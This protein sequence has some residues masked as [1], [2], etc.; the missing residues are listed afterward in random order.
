MEYSS[1][2]SV[3]SGLE[4][5]FD[6]VLMAVFFEINALPDEMQTTTK[7]R[8]NEE[9]TDA[10]C[11]CFTGRLSRLVNCLSGISNKVIIKISDAEDMGNIISIAKEKYSGEEL[12]N[13]VRRELLERGYSKDVVDEW[14]G[15]I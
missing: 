8:L 2:K 14:V 7:K 4:C 1:D 9:M 5:N 11:K 6:E 3:H 10:E 12:V 15:Y 13:H